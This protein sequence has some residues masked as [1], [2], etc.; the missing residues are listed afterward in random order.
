[1]GGER[2]RM[3]GRRERERENTPDSFRFHSS[4]QFIASQCMNVKKL[5]EATERSNENK[6]VEQCPELI[7]GWNKSC[8]QQ[9]KWKNLVIHR[10][11]GKKSLFHNLDKMYKFLER[12]KL[13]KLTNEKSR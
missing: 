11:S 13:L 3:G 1:M 6:Q 9:Q 7:Q 8:S 4:L 12:H 2:I 10:V 5:L